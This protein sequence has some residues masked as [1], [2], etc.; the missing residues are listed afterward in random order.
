NALLLID[1]DHS[2]NKSSWSTRIINSQIKIIDEYTIEGYRM[3]TGWAKLRKVY[4]Y[5]QFSKPIV[6][7]IMA[8]GEQLYF[9]NKLVNG[10]RLR[11]ALNFG[12][13]KSEPLLIK[14]GLSAVSVENAQLN[15]QSEIS[16]QNFDEV[17]NRADEKWEKEL[18]KIK[19]EGSDLQKEIF[20]TSLYHMFIQPNIMSDV[21]GEYLDTYFNRQQLKQGDAHYSTFSLWDTY[22]AAHP[23]YTI[24]Q[25]DLT[26]HFVNS[27][28]RQYKT[29]GYLPIWQLWGQENYCMIGNHSIPV[30]VDAVFKGIKGIDVNQAYDAVKQSSLISHPNAPFDVWEKYG[31]MPENRQTQSVSITLEMAYDDWCVAQ[32]SKKMQ[33]TDDYERFLKRSKF[34][35]NLYNKESGFFQSKDDEG[36]WMQPFDPLKYGANGGNPFTEGNA[37]QYFWYVPQDVKDLI[38]LTGGDNPFIKKLDTFFSLEQHNSE[39]NSNASGFI[40]QYAHGNEPSHH[41]AYLYD[42]TGQPSKT[43]FYVHKILTELYNN[44]SAGYAGNDDCG[45]MSAWYVFSSMGFYPVNPVNGIYVIGTPLLESAEIRLPSGKS[46][47]IKAPKSHPDDIYIQSVL[48]NGKEYKNSYIKHSD[49][50]NGG[51]MEFKMGNKPSRWATKKENRP[52]DTLFFEQKINNIH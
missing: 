12:N 19:I 33:Q 25:P 40:G 13:E 48:L 8:D 18:G 49:I 29:Y 5:I 10:T 2:M 39:L 23:L 37:W 21:N 38:Q 34:Y 3:I 35:R 9:D 43:Q 32:F 31:Y 36:K 4:F 20:Y 47:V 16:D 27:M 15:L 46:F 11:T 14:V 26:T 6:N 50:V 24:L 45:E 52:P 41:V 42:Y 17:A 28:L 51:S 22:R 30:I 44:S 7:N 1:L